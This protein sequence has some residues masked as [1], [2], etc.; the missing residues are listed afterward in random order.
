MPHCTGPGSAPSPPSIPDAPSCSKRP[1]SPRIRECGTAT[2]SSQD[3]PLPLRRA[4]PATQALPQRRLHPRPLRNR[5]NYA[6]HPRHILRRNNL[7]SS[8]LHSGGVAGTPDQAHRG[9]AAPW[10]DIEA[11]VSARR[12]ISSEETRKG[13]N[14]GMVVANP[15]S[16]LPKAG[17]GRNPSVNTVKSASTPSPEPLELCYA[18]SSYLATEQSALI[19]TPVRTLAIHA[20]THKW[21]GMGKGKGPARYT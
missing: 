6:T 1:P 21:R 3:Q 4:L 19:H 12:P 8:I 15:L 17:L 7:P 11:A 2:V 14:A 9:L 16:C 18:S 13:R 5:L 20:D 10:A